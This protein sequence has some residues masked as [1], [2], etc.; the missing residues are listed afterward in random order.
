MKRSDILQEEV[1]VVNA[2]G[3][4]RVSISLPGCS[5]LDVTPDVIRQAVTISC[6]R[7][8]HAFGGV[9]PTEFG[10]RD[11]EHE[12][13]A[14]GKEQFL[15]YVYEHGILV[16]IF[17]PM[18]KLPFFVSAA[19]K[20][21]QV[22]RWAR[23]G[24]PFSTTSWHGLVASFHAVSGAVM[25]ILVGC[26][27]C[28]YSCK[29]YVDQQETL[30]PVYDSSMFSSPPKI[31]RKIADSAKRI[32]ELATESTSSDWDN[33]YPEVVFSY[34]TGT[35]AGRDDEGCG[36]GLLWVS[37]LQR[38]LFQAGVPSFSGLTLPRSRKWKT[39]LL[40]LSDKKRKA[41]VL[42]V[43]LTESLYKSE[44]CFD[45]IYTACANKIPL[46]V[47]RFDQEANLK[48]PWADL[49]KTDADKAVKLLEVKERLNV[50][51]NPPRGGFA[52]M[53]ADVS[54]NLERFLKDVG[55]MIG[56]EKL[57][58]TAKTLAGV[59]ELGLAEQKEYQLQ[60]LQED[61][62]KLREEVNKL[63]QVNKSQREST[64]QKFR[65]EGMSWYS[66]TKTSTKT[67]KTV[68]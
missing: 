25:V 20:L 16:L 44:P 42:V 52:G 24:L 55:N 21:W 51:T 61:G 3:E 37:A 18:G 67:S 35:R 50:E 17:V 29:M 65:D 68:D 12:V 26:V 7:K 32:V 14:N 1:C 62:D 34:A 5:T 13:A 66:G 63:Q 39:L 48:D 57:I 8:Q 30:R 53:D 10:V 27:A 64:L 19:D 54:A 2:T 9:S 59:E 46:I 22:A 40:R 23:R 6:S 41:K 49:C 56:N 43:L 58:K 4:R 11:V 38:I 36:P 60:Q 33:F 15:G 45:E 28:A 47:L 31:T